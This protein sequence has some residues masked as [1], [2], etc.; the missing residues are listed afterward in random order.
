MTTRGAYGFVID[1]VEKIAFN[2]YESYPAAFGEQMLSWLQDQDVNELKQKVKDLVVV[3]D[4]FSATNEDKET[5]SSYM[6]KRYGGD[7][8]QSWY[9]LAYELLG[10]IDVTM[11][12]GIMIDSG[13]FPRKY[14]SC[15]WTYIVDLD[16]MSFEIYTSSFDRTPI[17]RFAKDKDSSGETGKST[18]LYSWS[19]D[20]LPD[21]LDGITREK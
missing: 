7:D 17:G 19:L 13:D 16:T 4:D 15:M 21:T 3:A 10:N 6:K 9:D 20:A 18:L 8:T 12:S 1:G 11:E 5:F 14:F 2:K